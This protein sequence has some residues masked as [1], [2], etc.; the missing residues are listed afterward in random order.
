MSKGMRYCNLIGFFE[1]A[2]N[3][4]KQNT[5]TEAFWEAGTEPHAHAYARKQN[6]KKDEAETSRHALL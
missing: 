5:Q 4:A 1:F 2:P 3:N 6:A